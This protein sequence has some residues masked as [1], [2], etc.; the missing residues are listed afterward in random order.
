MK[1]SRILALCRSTAMQRCIVDIAKYLSPTMKN[2]L[3]HLLHLQRWKKRDSGGQFQYSVGL[4]LGCSIQQ[5]DQFQ[6]W[7]RVFCFS[8]QYIGDIITGTAKP[9]VS[10]ESPLNFLEGVEPPKI[11]SVAAM[12]IN[13]PWA[14]KS[15]SDKTHQTTPL[16]HNKIKIFTPRPLLNLPDLFPHST[17]A[18]TVPHSSCLWHWN[19]SPQVVKAPNF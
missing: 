18:H 15:N 7:P 14:Y 9:W 19:L 6:Q 13:V 4:P 11:Y 10:A 8:R 5:L 2:S 1:H 3:F 16:S 17:A 12:H